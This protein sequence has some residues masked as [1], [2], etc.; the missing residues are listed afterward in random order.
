MKKYIWFCFVFLLLVFPLASAAT[1][2][3]SI[4]NSNLDLEKDV[5]IEI[6]STPVQKFLAKEGNYEFNVP[7]GKYTLTARK[8]LLDVQED[9]AIVS[10][11]TFVVDL[12]LLP[13]F[14]TEEEL[15]GEASE[16]LVDDQTLTASST[17]TEWWR[18][19]LVI[20]ILG[21]LGW[22]YAKMRRKYGPLSRFRKEMK[23]EHGK[24]IEQHKE[25]I[26]KEPGYLDEVLEII[27]KNDGW[28]T[29]KQ[30]RKEMLHLSEAKISLI[31]TELEHKGVVEK[32]KKGRGNVVVL[33]TL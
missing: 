26:A 5:L 32:I 27:K 12:F 31:I 24:T 25:E 23:V 4:Y 22:R 28:V 29:Q 11:G 21:L 14:R 15:W 30:I 3:G 7:L 17:T 13:D 16:Q 8:G 18:Y 20:I 9:T 1:L 2:K 19:L 10:D 6:N 33:R